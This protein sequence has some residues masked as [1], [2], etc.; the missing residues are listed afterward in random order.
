MSAVTFDTLKFAEATRQE[1]ATKY[2]LRDL[3]LHITMHIGKILDW[4]TG[5]LVAAMAALIKLL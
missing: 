5:L 3:E 2:D 4:Q 1:L